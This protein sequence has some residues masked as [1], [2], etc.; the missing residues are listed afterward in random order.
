MGFVKFIL[1][2]NSKSCKLFCLKSSIFGEKKQK[3]LGCPQ[4][5][6]HRFMCKAPSSGHSLLN[7]NVPFKVI[8]RK[9]EVF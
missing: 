2:M 5:F 8:L 3:N 6:Y 4:E 9:F 1:F 7:L